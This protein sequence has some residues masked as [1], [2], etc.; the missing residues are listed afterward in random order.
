MLKQGS[1]FGEYVI[2]MVNQLDFVS[3]V[4]AYFIDGAKVIPDESIWLVVAGAFEIIDADGYISTFQ[5][6][7]CAMQ[8]IEARGAGDQYLQCRYPLA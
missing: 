8:A 4:H 3:E 6:N 7:F 5:Q 2:E 1:V